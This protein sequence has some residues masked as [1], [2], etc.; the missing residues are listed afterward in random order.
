MIFFQLAVS[1]GAAFLLCLH[2]FRKLRKIRGGF[3]IGCD[4]LLEKRN[5]MFGMGGCDM[6]LWKLFVINW[7]RR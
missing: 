5:G 6:G 2:A 1:W 4:A 7:V 3:E